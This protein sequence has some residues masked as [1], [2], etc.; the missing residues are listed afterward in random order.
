MC[1]S[2]PEAPDKQGQIVTSESALP[3]QTPSGR[4]RRASRWLPLLA[5]LALVAAETAWQVHAHVGREPLI[6]LSL[7]SLATQRRYGATEV[8]IDFAPY[9]RPATLKVTLVRIRPG[10]RDEETEVT[11]QFIARENGAVGNL[12]GL[13]EGEYVLRA[14]VFG[15]PPGRKDLL[16]EEDARVSFSVPSPPPLDLA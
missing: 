8:A 9:S 1:A 10:G 14:R 5:V 13:I 6:R 12:S 2:P 15:Q 3:L 4:A 7:P 16:I 11:D